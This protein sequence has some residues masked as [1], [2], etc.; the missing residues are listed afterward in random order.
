M[1]R[2]RARRLAEARRR[3]R[4]ERLEARIAELER[5]SLDSERAAVAR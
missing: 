5:K 2:S 1:P 4:I 3:G